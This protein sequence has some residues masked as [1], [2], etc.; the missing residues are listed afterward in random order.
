MRI[1]IPVEE[2]R[3]LQSPVCGHFG[4]APA[5]L[6]VDTESGESRAIPNRNQHHGHGG[7]QPLRA[8]EGESIEGMVV[9]GIGQGAVAKLKAQGVTVYM[10]TQA[11]VAETIEALKA[12]TLQ[13]VTVDMACGGHAHGEGHGG[14]CGR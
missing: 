8:L 1:C 3:G 9:G 14:G 4:S 11:T 6:V 12:G 5:F 13:E 10:A 7:C 2:D